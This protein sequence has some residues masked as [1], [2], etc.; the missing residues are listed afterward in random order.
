MIFNFQ[1]LSLVILTGLIFGEYTKK[2]TKKEEN[3]IYKTLL[4]FAYIT[5]LLYITNYILMQNTANI[6]FIKLYL[7]SLSLTFSTL[8]LYYITFILKYKYIS[9]QSIYENKLKLAKALFITIN[10]FTMILLVI[11]KVKID[12]NQITG[13]AVYINYII[14]F[15]YTIINIVSILSYY[16]NLSIKQSNMLILTIII[17][18]A[19]NMISYSF[20]K[21]PA[22][23]SSLTLVAILLFLNSD[24]TDE[25]LEVLEL[26]REHARKNNFD[27]NRFLKY[28]SHEIRTPLNTIDGFCQ[29]IEDSKDIESIKEDTKDIRKASRALIDKINA[30]IDMN[31]IES[32]N[33]EI[34]NECYNT[35]DV[36]NNI[37]EITKSK[38]KNSKVKFII[39]IE[40]TIPKTLIGDSERIEQIV[41]SIINNSIKYTNEGNITLDINS[42]NSKSMCRLKITISDTGIG[43]KE[44]EL[45][46]IFNN[47][48]KNDLDYSDFNLKYSGKLL[49]L[50]NGKI[51]V[52]SQ[53]GKGS[54]FTITIDQK[55][56]D[57]N[58][59]KK[60]TT[61]NIRYFAATNK[62]ILLV[63][64]N[65]LNL[66]VASK[67]LE[68]YKVEII[69]TLSGKECLDVLEHDNNFDLILMDDLMPE[70]S[71]TETLDILRKIERVEGY[72]IPVVVL[73]ANAISGMKNK[74]L[75]AGFDDYLAKPIDK[76]E[77]NRIL[78]KFLKDN[79]EN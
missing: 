75:T 36:I 44:S 71:G 10:M 27:K 3:T 69:E 29:V 32:G 55:N 42:I 33:L 23:N 24:N 50:M 52:E 18:L 63:D 25:Y 28:L 46:N 78:K 54:K 53:E 51:D 74:Y 5:Q 6:F 14:I 72:K 15:I 39:N 19:C 16:K 4:T 79:K 47:D 20:I 35:K 9:K 7:I 37:T 48:K 60:T 13:Q 22:I 77:L 45:N 73:T 70:M 66:K 61:N 17:I 57:S 67:L 64:D 59:A 31:I 8:T 11:S 2:R 76:Y 34:I 56:S 41:L 49:E 40:D 43:I 21:I 65:K 12:G 68:P 38:L 62:R 26:E 58:E 1:L 30:I